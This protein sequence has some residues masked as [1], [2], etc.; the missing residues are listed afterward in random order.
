MT[1]QSA[2]EKAEQ[3][4]ER[5]KPLKSWQRWG[6]QDELGAI[7]LITPEKL[8]A[9][10]R[11]VTLGLP[12][13]MGRP[14]PTAPGGN[15]A[16]P[17]E[18][19]MRRVDAGGGE[20]GVVDY[21]GM[22]FHAPSSTHLDALCHIWDQD[23]MWNGRDPDREVGYDGVSWAGVEH[24]GNGI[25]TRGVLLD[26]AAHR[27]KGYVDTGEPVTGDELREVARD[28]DIQP[29]DALVV[30][31][32]REKFEEGTGRIWSDQWERPGL[33]DSCLEFF[34]EA[35]CSMLV[36]DMMDE[37]PITIGVAYSV[38]AL[39]FTR[40]VALVDNALLGPLVAAC[41]ANGRTDFL[42]VVAPLKV[43]GGTGSPVNALAV[44]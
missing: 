19:F 5:L 28:L 36:W 7:N 26:V 13:S 15:N 24:W 37:R 3:F 25:L 14:V 40:G 20:G 43:V 10:T 12:I 1:E 42:V 33:D 27:P 31:S 17:A 22:Q 21:V 4:R 38:H 29:G 2:A 23:G 11:L 8:V 44:L 32:G 6:D 39:V 34:C 16:H 35:D 18:H 41:N 30:H 9:A